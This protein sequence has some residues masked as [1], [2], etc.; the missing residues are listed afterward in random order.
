MRYIANQRG[1]AAMIIVG[2]VAVVALGAAIYFA[3]VN[4]SSL[5]ATT[6]ASPSPA[7][8]TSLSQ[9]VPA[10]SQAQAEFRQ[11]KEDM[12]ILR[13]AAFFNGYSAGF[14]VNQDAAQASFLASN[15][16]PSLIKASP[17][18]YF[19]G[20]QNTPA[21]W[22][23]TDVKNTADAVQVGVRSVGYTNEIAI[24]ATYDKASNLISKVSCPTP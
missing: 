3:I 10:N 5:P 22:D 6:K 15:L 20:Q 9:I 18:A 4:R 19:C 23:I 11:N 7:T 24:Q 21:G 16:T 8:A 13:V 2:L 12:A 1:D 17:T 14:P